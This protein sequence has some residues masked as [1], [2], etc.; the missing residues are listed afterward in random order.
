MSSFPDTVNQSAGVSLTGGSGMLPDDFQSM[1][2]GVEPDILERFLI[3]L[4]DKFPAVDEAN[5]FLELKTGISGISIAITNQR[6]AI[7]HL[8]TLLRNTE[9]F[10]REDQLAQLK[11]AEE[12]LRR[13]IIES[14]QKAVNIIAGRVAEV[15][16]TYKQ[17]VLTLKDDATLSSADNIGSLGVQFREIEELRT[18]GRSAKAENIWNEEWED[19]IKNFV[20]ACQRLEDLERKMEEYVLRARGIRNARRN[21]RITFIGIAATIITSIIAITLGIIYG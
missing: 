21:R 14:Y 5:N 3:L 6:D 12:H 9:N 10:S 7:S 1:F 16:Q 19:G 18:K 8:V 20:A 17:E 15:F 4:R 11:D 13:A 2:P